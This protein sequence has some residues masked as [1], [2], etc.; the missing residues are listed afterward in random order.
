MPTLCLLLFVI[1]SLGDKLHNFVAGVFIPQYHYP[2]AVALCFGKV[3]ISVLFLNLLHLLGTVSLHSYSRVLGEKLLVPSICS[4]IYG[5]L[6]MW[7][8]ANSS[9]SG[10]FP[11][12][13]PLLTLFTMVLSFLLNLQSPLSTL[14]SILISFFSGTT[15]VVTVFHGVSSVDFLEY[16]YA[17]LALILFCVSLIWLAKV[18]E[19]ERQHPLVAQASVFDI[20]YAHLVNQS[21]VLGLLWLL[22]SD[23]PWCVLSQGSWHSLLFHG[24]LAAILLL[25]MV[26]NFFV[27]ITVL[28][29]SPVV[30]AL[31]HSAYPLALFFLQFI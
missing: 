17:P 4:S 9:N 16:I 24:Y 19:V 25:G 8:K 2:Y 18:S 20:Y 3:M 29:F 28:C 30:A 31:L 5:V 21:G 14:I 12:V 10:L 7:A 23:N 26:L 6:S 13:L 11:L 15:F 27:G 1:Y 22:H